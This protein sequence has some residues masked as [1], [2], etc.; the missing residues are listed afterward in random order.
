MRAHV[1]VMSCWHFGEQTHKWQSI[2][3]MDGQAICH[4]AIYVLARHTWN[5]E[6]GTGSTRSTASNESNK[7]L[8]PLS[9]CAVRATFL[10]N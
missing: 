5:M 6:P 1:Y 7:S 4:L 3:Q 8:R 9:H 2:G 10:F